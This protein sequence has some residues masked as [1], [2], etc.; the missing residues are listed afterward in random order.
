LRLFEETVLVGERAITLVVERPQFG[1]PVT[2]LIQEGR[3]T[4]LDNERL[5][6]LGHVL[7]RAQ[8]AAIRV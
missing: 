2:G 3:V 6:A 1:E 8:E 5:A 7:A 4:W